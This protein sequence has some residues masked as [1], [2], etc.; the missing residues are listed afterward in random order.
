MGALFQTKLGVRLGG[1]RRHIA[2]RTNRINR[3]IWVC[4]VDELMKGHISSAIITPHGGIPGNSGYG[5]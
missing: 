3:P 4:P 5:A 1:P 2:K